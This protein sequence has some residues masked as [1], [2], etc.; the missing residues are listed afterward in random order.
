MPLS[1]RLPSPPLA[2][3]IAS[4]RLPTSRHTSAPSKPDPLTYLRTPPQVTISLLV[5]YHLTKFLWSR[6]LDPDSNALPLHSSLMDLVGQLL[7]VLCFELASLMGVVV[8]TRA[9]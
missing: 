6:G 7:R 8:E 2:S 3:G 9:R 5:A 1:S 4:S